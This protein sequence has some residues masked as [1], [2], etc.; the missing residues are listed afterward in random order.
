MSKPQTKTEIAIEIME[1]NAELPITEVS[2]LI[3]EALGYDN[4][5]RAKSVYRW[6]VDHGRVSFSEIVRDPT[7]VK[8]K[9]AKP[10]VEV[11]PPTNTSNNSA[12]AAEKA[13]A[14]AKARAAKAAAEVA[15]A[16]V[17]VEA[18]EIQAAEVSGFM[19]AED[20]YEAEVAA[21]QE[22]VPAE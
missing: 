15:E 13:L 4:I 16:E 3:Q 20:A 19:A 1:A 10:E 17:Q 2:A 18:A 7:A 12:S 21:D 6:V 9:K 14:R 11:T 22:L 5:Q 8:A